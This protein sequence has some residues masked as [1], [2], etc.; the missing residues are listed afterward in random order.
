MRGDHAAGGYS[1]KSQIASPFGTSDRITRPIYRVAEV[2]RPA[3]SLFRRCPRPHWTIEVGPPW[4]DLAVFTRGS[5]TCKIH[6]C[7]RLKVDLFLKNAM[8]AD[9]SRSVQLSPQEVQTRADLAEYLSKSLPGDYKAVRVAE[10]RQTATYV[11]SYVLE[12]HRDEGS[13]ISRRLASVF[14]EVTQLRDETLLLAVDHKDHSYFLDLQHPRFQ[15]MHSID[16]SSRTDQT[17]KR[18]TEGDV[19]GFDHAWMPRHFLRGTQR[20]QLTGFKFRYRT[21]IAGVEA[22]DRETVDSTTGEIIGGWRGKSKFRMEVAEDANAVEE[23]ASLMQLPVFQGRK[24]LEQVQFRSVDADQPSDYIVSGIYAYGKVVGKGTSIGGHFLTIDSVIDA[25]ARVISRI[26]EDFSLGWIPESGGHVLRGD[27]FLFRFPDDVEIIDLDAFTASLFNGARP[28]RLFGVPHSASER[29][30]D[31]EAID[32][33]TGDP[34]SIELTP[35]WMRVYLPRGSCGNIVARLFTNFQH[36]MSSEV[37]LTVGDQV[38][39]FALELS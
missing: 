28:F 25:Y 18:L 21:E 7:G 22:V 1:V 32:L 37:E 19:A 23:Y 12:A 8:D 17:F 24:A 20:G 13:T 6:S 33:H 38:D 4:F 9:T 26:E 3:R 14:Q 5:D 11:K 27:P 10:V 30:V 16:I 36:A 35:E 34:L 39:P 15:L 2:S 31:V 29:R